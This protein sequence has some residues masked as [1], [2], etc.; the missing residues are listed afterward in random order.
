M[1]PMDCYI[2]VTSDTVTLQLLD[3]ILSQLKRPCGQQSTYYI[4]CTSEVCLM[5]LP[6]GQIPEKLNNHCA[7]YLTLCV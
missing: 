3:Y 4:I 5:Y 6:H 7:H 2:Y 1:Q